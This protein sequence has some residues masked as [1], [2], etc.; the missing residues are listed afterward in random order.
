LKTP[1]RALAA[2]L[3][4]CWLAVAACSLV[5]DPGAL[6]EGCAEGMKAC[7]VEDTARCVSTADPEYGCARDSCVP[8]IL[9]HAVEVCGASGECAVG[10][11]EPNYENCDLVAKTG[12]EVDLDNS[13]EHCGGCGN[14]CDAALRSMPHASNARCAGGRCVVDQCQDG[15]GD[16]DG[17][18]SNGC[19]QALSED[20]C[21]RCGGCPGTTRCN[22][23][24][25]RCEQ[26]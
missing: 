21:G 16:C 4:T 8:C 17:A 20:D 18:A 26:P 23:G 15:Y 14:S 22:L 5:V 13:Y 7:E 12:C 6:Q 2:S 19:E 24:S 1:A 25:G 10:T 3:L 11:C 9:A